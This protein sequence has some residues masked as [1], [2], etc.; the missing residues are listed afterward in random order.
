MKTTS[1]KYSRPMGWMAST[2]IALAGMTMLPDA[3]G[4][5]IYTNGFETS[6]NYLTNGGTG[7]TGS[8]VGQGS[9][10]GAVQNWTATLA[11]GTGQ[12]VTDSQGAY[13]TEMT[14]PQ[15]DQMLQAQY[16]TNSFT[17]AQIILA[18]NNAIK[19]DF[20]FTFKFAVQEDAVSNAGI[21]IGLRSTAASAASHPNGMDFGVLRYTD[22][23]QSVY[24]FTARQSDPGG[25]SYATRIGTDTLDINEWYTFS[26]NLDWD[27]LTFSGTVYDSSDN[28]VTSFD[29]VAIWDRDGVM[30]DYGFNQLG[31]YIHQ[32]GGQPYVLLDDIS[33]TAVPEP[34]TLALALLGA[35]AA[36]YYRR[37]AGAARR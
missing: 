16:G 14:P 4:Q 2:A 26:L 11:G 10:G 33:I 8:V 12:I 9:N 36:V 6:Q 18:T 34:S 30:H 32:K 22:D 20:N 24:G 23:G 31:V 28:L 37:R 17:L 27:S 29:N 35:A 25:A 3:M 7:S 19:Q 1:H 5:L 15:G 21:Y 13:S